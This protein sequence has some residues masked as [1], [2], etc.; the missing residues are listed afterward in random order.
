VDPFN[1]K[2]SLRALAA[3]KRQEPVS[4]PEEEKNPVRK[5]GSKI[6]A[7]IVKEAPPGLLERAGGTALSGLATVGNLLDVHFRGYLEDQNHRTRLT[8]WLLRSRMR[9]D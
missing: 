5:L 8:N 7:D 9:T 2:A 1:L 4:V 6:Q 3:S